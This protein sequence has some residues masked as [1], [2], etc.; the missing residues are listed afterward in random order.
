[1]PDDP[2]QLSFNVW[3]A[4]NTDPGT[5]HAAAAAIQEKIPA[6]ERKV[7]DA[8]RAVLPNGMT[9]CETADWLGMERWSVSP[10]FRPLE[11]KGL[12]YEATTK[13]A[14]TGR[15]QIVWKART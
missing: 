6:L 13:I 4:R 15:S 9:I 3:P 12:I 7:L 1:M 2:R 11:R 8:L 10:R 5:S 14:P